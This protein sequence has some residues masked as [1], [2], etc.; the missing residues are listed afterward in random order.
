MAEFASRAHSETHLPIIANVLLCIAVS[1]QQLPSTLDFG[2]IQMCYSVKDSVEEYTSTVTSLVTSDDEIAASIEGLECLALLGKIC[3][4][5]GKLR[6]AWLSLRRAMNM[7]EIIGLH[8][9]AA[10]SIVGSDGISTS[11][12]TSVLM[13]DIPSR[14]ITEP[15]T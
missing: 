5:A 2:S 15:T 13:A 7:A 11:R 12:K 3:L 1:M 4:N 10:R 8:R 14:S 6:R 9:N